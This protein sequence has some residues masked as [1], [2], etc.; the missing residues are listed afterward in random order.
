MELRSCM[1]LWLFLV[2][3]FLSSR[4]FVDEVNYLVELCSRFQYILLHP[5]LLAQCIINYDIKY[6]L[7]RDADQACDNDEA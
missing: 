7:G 2:G 5:G 3:P 4:A 6:R 1:S